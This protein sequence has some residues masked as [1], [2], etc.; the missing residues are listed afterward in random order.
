MIDKQ[1]FSDILRQTGYLLGLPGI[2]ERQRDAF[3][4]ELKGESEDAIRAAFRNLAVYGERLSLINIQKHLSEYR[5]RKLMKESTEEKRK[6]S[7]AMDS[8]RGQEI[9]QEAQEALEKLFGKNWN[10]R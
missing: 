7:E 1:V 6:A 4:E 8:L 3:Y 10:R 5:S 2:E 9:P